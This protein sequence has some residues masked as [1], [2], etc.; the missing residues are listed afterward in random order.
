MNELDKM[1][2]DDEEENVLYE[3]SKNMYLKTIVWSFEWC[4]VSSSISRTQLPGV[5]KPNFVGFLRMYRFKVEEPT[6]Y[7]SKEC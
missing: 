7:Q 6:W 2:I 4:I 3:Q 1:A 5:E